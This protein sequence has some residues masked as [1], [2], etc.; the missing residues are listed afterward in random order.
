M[1]KHIYNN[2][3]ITKHSTIKK[4]NL[5]YRER[6]NNSRLLLHSMHARSHPPFKKKKM[7]SLSAIMIRF[8]EII[9]LMYNVRM[10]L[11]VKET[12]RIV[13]LVFVLM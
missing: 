11:V 9:R 1:L 13:W 12:K 7:L 10:G 2:A 5:H 4:K 8:R 3:Y 6:K